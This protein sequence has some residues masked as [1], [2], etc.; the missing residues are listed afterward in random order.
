MVRSTPDKVLGLP[1]LAAVLA[2]HRAAGRR[3][4][5]CHG[6]F[7][8]LH[9]GHVRHLKAARN[10]ADVLVVTI[11]ADRFVNK[12]PGR[13]AFNE[14]LRAEF[15]AAIAAVDY[16]GI[17]HAESAT[18]LIRTLKP[19]FYVKGSDYVRREDDPTGKIYDEEEAVLAV[20]G[21]VRFTDEIVFSSSHLINVH[22]DVLPPE[23]ERW[24][25]DFRRRRTADEVLDWLER[26]SRLKVTVV[27]E[28]II[29]EY[30][31]CEGLGM[32][33]KDPILALLHRSIESHAGGS[34]AVANHVA[35]LGCAV[36]LVGQL[37]EVDRREDFIREHLAPNV[38]ANF[39]TRGNAPTVAK[40]RFV[41]AYTRVR[42]FELYFMSEHEAADADQEAVV[43][44]VRRAL[45]DADV[46]IV[47]D[48]G[49]GMISGVVVDQLVASRPFL[50]VNTQA[51]AGNRGFNTI[52]K[53]PRADYVCMAN[54]EVQ[55]EARAM[56][57]SW[58]ELVT[59]LAARVKCEKFTI[60]RGR[61]GTV[62]CTLPDD[63]VDAPALATQV[64]DRVGAGDAVLA[65][66]GPLV[67]IGAPWDVVALLANLAGAQMVADLGNRSTL[68][69][70][71]LSKAVRALLK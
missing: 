27:G 68:N 36:N 42:L 26:A 49:H 70:V 10:L 18:E 41:D 48:Y 14:S 16:V 62:H 20:G 52:S 19:D 60:T 4:A 53:Y 9:P 54:H 57:A 47:A 7:D 58:R 24:L 31:F 64:T 23:V 51:N 3:I 2:R 59:V 67:A 11:T 33:S 15:L 61:S 71:G 1:E 65:V 44:S 56:H 12:G 55:L 63:V 34:V 38:E 25:G 37:G 69:R 13:P 22:L 30:S 8:V 6:V 45:A 66:T 32:S 17:N 28:P 5:L 39:T 40:R 21:Q 35:G 43:A 50:V 46:A 29:D